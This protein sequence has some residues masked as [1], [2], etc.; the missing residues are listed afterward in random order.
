MRL[1]PPR[2]GE[3]DG[4]AGGASGGWRRVTEDDGSDLGAVRTVS[5]GLRAGVERG[6]DV[7][8]VRA[9][10][11]VEHTRRGRFS[12]GVGAIVA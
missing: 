5:Q 2:D 4:G 6:G 11:D 7:A 8:A 3:D 12:G 9:R 10:V 1:T